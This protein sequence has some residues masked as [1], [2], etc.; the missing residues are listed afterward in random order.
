MDEASLNSNNLLYHFYFNLFPVLFYSPQRVYS[1]RDD[2]AQNLHHKLVELN[3]FTVDAKFNI[4]T[5]SPQNTD[6]NVRV[7]AFCKLFSKETR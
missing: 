6:I 1:S 2:S 3:F 4:Q 5:S 7:K